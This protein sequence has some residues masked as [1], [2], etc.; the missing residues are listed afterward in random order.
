M[1]ETRL[2]GV[3]VT[4]RNNWTPSWE[5]YPGARPS[6]DHID[7]L[8]FI[9]A[10]AALPTHPPLQGPAPPPPPPPTGSAVVSRAICGDQWNTN[11]GPSGPE[12]SDAGYGGCFQSLAGG[13]CPGLGNASA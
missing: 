8:L 11:G 7:M 5:W 6:A 2:I 4:D 3:D 10:F 13:A 1:S 12:P 9:L